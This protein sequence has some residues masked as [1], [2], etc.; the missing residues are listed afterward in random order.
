VLRQMGFW[1]H[2]GLLL[3]GSNP[4]SSWISSAITWDM[5]LIHH[6]DISTQMVHLLFC[7]K[8]RSRFN[9]KTQEQHSR[10]SVTANSLAITT[11]PITSSGTPPL[12]T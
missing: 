6:R 11:A 8:W 10:Q 3:T 12:L 7:Y 1:I 9:F 5:T 2:N 4:L